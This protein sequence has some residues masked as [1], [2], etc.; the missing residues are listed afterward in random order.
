MIDYRCSGC[1]T[2]FNG[3]TGTVFEG[4]HRRPLE[5]VQLVHCM[6]KGHTTGAIA[7]GFG[8]NRSW[9]VE[10]RVRLKSEKW[11]QDLCVNQF[12]GV[13]LSDLQD[14]L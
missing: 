10:L 12:V 4:T 6:A 14:E 5:L 9:L 13:R 1:G 7:T 11:F 2:I 8:W 3:W